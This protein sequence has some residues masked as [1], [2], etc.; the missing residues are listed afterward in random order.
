MQVIAVPEHGDPAFQN[1]ATAVVADLHAAQE[2][3][4][5]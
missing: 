2:L 5:I 1:E 3:L 4:E